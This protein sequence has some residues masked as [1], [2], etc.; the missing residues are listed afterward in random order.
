VKGRYL[1]LLSKALGSYRSVVIFKYL[2][3]I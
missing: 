3:H 1:D 2:T